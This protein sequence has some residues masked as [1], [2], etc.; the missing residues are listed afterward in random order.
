MIFSVDNET[1][2]AFDFDIEEVA[3]TVCKAVLDSEGCPEEVEINMLITDDEGIHEMNR[4]FRD[5]DRETDVLSFPNVSYEDPGDFGVFSG[6]QRED[7]YDPDARAIYLGDIV[8][9]EN[10]VRS[11]A[12]EYGHSQKREFA[13]LTA[14]SMLHLCGYDHMEEDEAAVMEAKQA[15]VLE[16]LGIVRD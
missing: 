5:I 3:R 2:A 7:I 10:R 12:E 9:N 4:Q 13:F 16:G 8:I 14:H 11:Q 6:D 1:G 15:A